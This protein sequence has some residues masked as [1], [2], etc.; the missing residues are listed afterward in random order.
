MKF[1]YVFTEI[2]EKDLNDILDYISTDLKNPIAAS[3]F[4]DKV[5]KCIEQLIVF[6]D[7]GSKVINEY[8]PKYEIRKKVVNNYVIY[9]LPNY[10]LKRIEIIRV[11]YARK[12]M[13]KLWKDSDMF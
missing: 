2:A 11:V 7:S 10:D 13:N 5:K 6:P 3:N 4:L 1:K 8:L 12:D 9:Y